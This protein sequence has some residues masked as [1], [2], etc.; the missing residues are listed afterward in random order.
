VM[1][2]KEGD[3]KAMTLDNKISSPSWF[4]AAIILLDKLCIA[5]CE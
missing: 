4:I 5:S 1:Y 3:I 2:I